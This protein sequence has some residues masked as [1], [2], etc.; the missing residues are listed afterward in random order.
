M[1]SEQR[2]NEIK[3]GSMLLSGESKPGY[4]PR[5][6]QGPKMG[7]CCSMNSKETDGYNMIN[8]KEPYDNK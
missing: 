8:E 6:C 2:Y 5:K 1:T 3:E 4:G 7:I